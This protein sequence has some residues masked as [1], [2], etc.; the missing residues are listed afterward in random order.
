MVAVEFGF[1]HFRS[2]PMSSAGSTWKAPMT[3]SGWSSADSTSMR[4]R[5]RWSS[6]SQMWPLTTRMNSW[7]ALKGLSLRRWLTG[8]WSS[9]NTMHTQTHTLALSGSK[10]QI[11]WVYLWHADMAMLAMYI[12]HTHRRYC[13]T[14]LHIRNTLNGEPFNTTNPLLCMCTNKS[15]NTRKE[16][17]SKV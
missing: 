9:T 3:L 1:L 4:T 15:R 13:Y 5:T 17:L 16:R 8:R 12:N 14:Y 7:A 11:V 10:I 2:H 6:T